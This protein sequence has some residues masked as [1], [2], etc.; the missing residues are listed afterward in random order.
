MTPL[1]GAVEDV[2]QAGSG[3]CDKREE[4]ECETSRWRAMQGNQSANNTTREGGWR[5]LCKV[6]G[7]WTTEREA[8]VDDAGQSEEVGVDDV[9]QSDGG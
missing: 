3:Q 6:M 7:Q 5:T 8:Q 1:E 4:G 2:R 9:G